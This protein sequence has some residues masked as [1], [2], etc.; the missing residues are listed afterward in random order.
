MEDVPNRATGYCTDDVSRGLMVT[1][2]KLQ[3]DPHNITA[4]RLASTYLA[5]M[6]DAQMDCGRF[7][8]FMSYGRDWLDACGTH[9][10][11][12]R[13]LWSLGFTMRHAARDSWKRVAKKAFDKGLNS[14]DWL[15]HT[16]SKAYATI[17]LVHAAS[18]G[19]DHADVARYRSAL[20][21]L[22]DGLKTLY[23]RTS[24]P[25]WQWFENEMTYDNARLP[26]ALLRAGHILGD[27]EAVAVGLR[28]L[29]FYQQITIENGIF[30]PIGN[31]G[32]F[33]RGGSRARYCQQPLEAAALTDASLAAFEATGDP[34]FQASAQ[35]GLDWYYG[36]NSRGVPMA[37]N[38]GCF[39]GLDETSV[40]RNMGAESTLAFLSTAYAL[41]ARP[42]RS[43][44]VAR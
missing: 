6:R 39:D 20:W 33:R 8:N 36:R 5:F 4:K 25:D 28:S 29:R 11:V 30:V 2:A 9:D 13:S 44:H 12:G 15:A 1:L 21:Q 16:R 19:V 26:E 34:A 41:A 27:D 37:H 18:S 35:I 22:A 17:G 7:H 43:L 3:I 10:S 42:A 38:G 23:A 32:W 14:L 24:A 31:R 40:N